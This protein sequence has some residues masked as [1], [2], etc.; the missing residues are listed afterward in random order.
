MSRLCEL[1]ALINCHALA[2]RL[3][4]LNAFAV[5]S[6]AKKDELCGHIIRICEEA[7]VPPPSITR[8][9]DHGEG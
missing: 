8:E 4:R 3:L 5:G 9:A 7:G 2:R 6:L 1:Q